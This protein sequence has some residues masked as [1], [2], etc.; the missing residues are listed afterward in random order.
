MTRPVGQMHN[1]GRRHRRNESVV[2]ESVQVGDSRID[3]MIATY[4][5]RKYGQFIGDRTAEEIKMGDW[6]RVAGEGVLEVQVGGWAGD[7]RWSAQRTAYEL[8]RDNRS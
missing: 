7:H 4:V 3:E 6:Q 1:R 5:R 2:S 8:D